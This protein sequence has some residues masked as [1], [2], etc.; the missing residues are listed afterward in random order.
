MVTHETYDVSGAL[1]GSETA[2]FEQTFVMRRATGGRWL[3]VAILP[4]AT[5]G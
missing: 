3:N 2:P 1:V 4:P 5:S